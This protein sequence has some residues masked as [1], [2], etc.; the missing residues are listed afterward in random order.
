MAE[1]CLQLALKQ[2]AAHGGGNEQ[3]YLDTPVYLRE[4]LGPAPVR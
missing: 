3:I 4:S 1:R 2:I